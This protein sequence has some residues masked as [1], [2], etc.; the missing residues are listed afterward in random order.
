MPLEC[1]PFLKEVLATLLVG[2]GYG[3]NRRIRV[4]KILY[5]YVIYTLDAIQT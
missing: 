1:T 3:S 2:L 5:S 4:A